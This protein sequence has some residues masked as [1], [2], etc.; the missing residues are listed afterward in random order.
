MVYIYTQTDIYTQIEHS[1]STPRKT[2][3]ET[4]NEYS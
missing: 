2:N 1:M 4:N 3:H